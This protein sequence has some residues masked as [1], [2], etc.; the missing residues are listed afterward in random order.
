METFGTVRTPQMLLLRVD[1][2]YQNRCQ[3]PEGAL[4]PWHCSPSSVLM[5]AGSSRRMVPW[6]SPLREM[7]TAFPHVGKTP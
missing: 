6:E 1:C 5:T 7:G 2:R 3:G 4:N